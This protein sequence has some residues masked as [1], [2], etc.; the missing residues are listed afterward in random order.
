MGEVELDA[1]LTFGWGVTGSLEV[2]GSTVGAV[3]GSSE[4]QSLAGLSNGSGL[5]GEEIDVSG[6]WVGESGL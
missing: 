5:L 4:V 3:E 6:A 1:D 2:F